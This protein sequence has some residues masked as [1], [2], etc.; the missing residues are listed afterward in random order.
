MYKSKKI[1]I[2]N[3]NRRKTIFNQPKKTM[4]KNI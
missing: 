1:L 4:D 2:N 3:K